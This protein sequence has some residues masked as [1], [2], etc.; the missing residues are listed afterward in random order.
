MNKTKIIKYSSIV[1]IVIGLVFIFVAFNRSGQEANISGKILAKVNLLNMSDHQ[2]G[3]AKITTTG[4]VESLGQVELKSQ[5]SARVNRVNFSVGDWVNAGQVIAIFENGDIAGQLL[6]AQAGLDAQL[7]ALAEMQKG[8]RA[9]QIQ[10]AQTAVNSAQSSLADAQQN[11]ENTKNKAEVDLNNVYS[12][13][14]TSLQTAANSGKKALLTLTDIQKAHFV[15]LDQESLNVKGA[16]E[17]AILAFLGEPFARDHS[18][19]TVSLL[20]GGIYGQ[21]KSLSPSSH[22]EIERLL[23]ESLSALKI[24]KNALDVIPTLNTFSVAESANLATE[25]ATM[26]GQITAVSASVSSL[27]AQKAVN[28]NLIAAAKTN[29]NMAKNALQSAQD[30]LN[31]TLAGASEEQ[32]AAQQARVKSAR[33][34]VAQVAAMYEKTVVRSPIDGKIAVLP[35][36]VGELVSPGQVVAMVVNDSGLEIKASIDSNDLNKINV[37]DKVLIENDEEGSVIRISP[38]IDP[39]TKKV[40]VDIAVTNPGNSTLVIGQFVNIEIIFNQDSQDD[41]TYLIPLTAIK[42]ES[43]GAFV[44]LVDDQQKIFQLAVELGQVIG[45]KVEVLSGLEPEMMI[46]DSVRGLVVGQQVEIIK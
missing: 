39:A 24:V 7:A 45:E 15:S 37:G 21:I 35:I 44:F 30:Q 43:Q 9:E 20:N 18:T 10:I 5:V 29:V 27:S 4:Q 46:V 14:Y 25:R 1:A 26:A 38:S 34:T 16:K 2:Q 40:Q 41:N 17:E 12:S 36:R 31:L 8:A 11:L 19:Y 28:Q 33:G 42:N 13:A 32:V 22:S 3:Q 23:T 6:Q